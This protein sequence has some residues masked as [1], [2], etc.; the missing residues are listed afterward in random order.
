MHA[1]RVVPT[2]RAWYIRNAR[3]IHATRVVTLSADNLG[4][5]SNNNLGGIA[6]GC[7]D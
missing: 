6:L 1:T 3:D 7:E 4:I 5:M 2:Q